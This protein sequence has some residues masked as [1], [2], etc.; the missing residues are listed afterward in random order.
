MRCRTV[1][2]RLSDG[3][4]RALAP[5]AAARLEA[6]LR[7]CPSCRAHRAALAR[8]QAASGPPA[9]RS[10]EDWAVFEHKLEARLD[11]WESGRAGRS[12]PIAWRPRAAFAAAAALVL[13]GA[14]LWVV[15]ARSGPE[16]GPFAWVPSADGIAPLIRE[17]E[18]DPGLEGAVGRYLS[19]SLAELAPAVDADAAALTAADPLFWESLSDD[20]LGAVAE[21]LGKETGLGG[22]Q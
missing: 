18:T 2:R 22:P 20:E 16:A 8:L 17:A 21:A 7:V 9:G 4:D 19:E 13:A 5:G 10:P 11:A 6:H 14:A 3:F 15:L 1:E 12:A